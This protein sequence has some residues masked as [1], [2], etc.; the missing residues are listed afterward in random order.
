MKKVFATAVLLFSLLAF[1]LILGKE[2]IGDLRP[3]LLPPTDQT[4]IENI[5]V[6]PGPLKA[7]EGFRVEV[8]AEELGSPRDLEFSPEGTLLVSV[9]GEGKIAALT[10]NSQGR[11]VKKDAVAN[12]NNPHGIVFFK[13]KL[14]IAEETRV[15]RYDW[16]EKLGQA[17]LEK[18]L[19]SL[20]KGGRHS[21][22]TLAF[23]K[24]GRMFISIG[25]TCDV[26]FEK[27][28]W[29]GAVIV[30]D[31]EG[32]N[33]Q[34]FAKGLRNAVFITVHP[35]TN[36][37]WGTEM[38]R[39]FLGD[40]LP[41]DEVNIIREEKD[42]GW[43]VCYGNK[44]Y[45]RNFGGES[46]N[47][48][49]GTEPPVYEIPAHSAPLGLAFIKSGQFPK[50]WQEDLLVAY[51]GSWNRSTPTGYK[52]VRIDLENGK[53][54]GG[55]DFLTGFLQDSSA[56]GRPADLIFGK[57]GSLYISDDKGGK[58]YRVSRQ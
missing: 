49:E 21:T 46:P 22:R 14:Y 8:I 5:Q 18:I 47:Y 38:G 10:K 48:C 51:H 17:F 37:L 12:L 27:N 52:V 41:P 53:A 30:S 57:D 6:Y 9:P 15:A 50:D 11:Y 25:S 56:V 40:S 19:F 55:H 35:E 33:P 45:D 24:E 44:V 23:N 26:C 2:K 42:Y 13:G 3:A 29:H 4:Q 39:D 28:S 36:E 31:S 54:V 16:N 43:P 58:I 20:P 32:N 34:V 1:A 7:P